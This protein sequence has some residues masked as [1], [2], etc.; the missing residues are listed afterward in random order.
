MDVDSHLGK[1]Y[2]PDLSHFRVGLDTERQREYRREVGREKE[3]ER[4]EE[5][6]R[7]GQG[8]RENKRKM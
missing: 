8:G 7:Q 6:E 1:K 2:L 4:G 3:R 5:R